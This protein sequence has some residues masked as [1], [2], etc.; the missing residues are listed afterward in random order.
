MFYFSSASV[1]P[2]DTDPED[3]GKVLAFKK[4]VAASGG[5][6]ANYDGPQD[7]R[8]TIRRHLERISKASVPQKRG[9]AARSPFRRPTFLCRSEPAFEATDFG[10]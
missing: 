4:R 10:K 5:L 1:S 7:F 8:E 6:Y 3:L 2:Q 9:R